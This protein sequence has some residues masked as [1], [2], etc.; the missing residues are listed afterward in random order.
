MKEILGNQ[1]LIT[2]FG[3]EGRSV[4]K[5][6]RKNYPDVAVA[7]ADKNPQSVAD[8]NNQ[9]FSG[10]QYLD[11]IGEFSTVV[12]S[13]GVSKNT[14][15]LQEAEHVTTATNLFF[16]EAPGLI[17]GVTGTKGKSTTSAL[18]HHILEYAGRDSRLVGNIG[19]PAL[20]SL[21]D[22]SENTV[23]VLEL[24]SYQLEDCRYSPHIAVVLPLRNEHLDYHSD[25]SSYV[26]AKR[27][28]VTHQKE[29]DIVVYNRQNVYSSEIAK[30]S[31]GVKVPYPGSSEIPLSSWADN[32]F[33]WINDPEHKEQRLMRVGSVPLLG[34]ANIENVLAAVFVALSLQI[35][36]H[37]I[38]EAIKSFKSLEHRLEEVGTVNNITFY[39]D[40]LATIPEATIHALEAL[41]ERVETLITGGF[42][43][44]IDYSLLGRAIAESN[45]LNT[46]LFPTTGEKIKKAILA[47]NPAR[48]IKIFETD[49]MEQAVKIAG[50]ITSPGKICLLSPASASYNLF[51]DYAERGNAFK[52]AVMK[53]KDTA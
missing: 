33:I 21:T 1:V 40:S 27:H 39:N 51:R 47:I 48:D 43:R 2:G 25:F 32:G 5:Y 10:D 4:L 15:Q 8:F 22:S 37:D 35:D 3:R 46:I 42:D 45:V 29:E 50:A 20:D 38:K 19:N 24:S 49:D 34:T 23:F 13:P 41:S 11:H 30:S 9:V 31:N 16:S 36:L 17:I 14:P 6:L 7:V 26:D 12:R 28:I 18:I 52:Q 44:G 53:I